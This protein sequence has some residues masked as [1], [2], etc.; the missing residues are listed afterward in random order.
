MNSVSNMGSPGICCKSDGGDLGCDERQDDGDPL[1]TAASGATSSRARLTR[2]LD[3][4]LLDV[5]QIHL[6]P[7]CAVLVDHPPFG[8]PKASTPRGKVRGCRGLPP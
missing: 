6:R 3:K 7:F 1:G 2:P 8:C 4:R 5:A